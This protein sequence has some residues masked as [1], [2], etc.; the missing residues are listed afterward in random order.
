MSGSVF[1]RVAMSE[2]SLPVDGRVTPDAQQVVVELEGQAERPAEAP[3]RGDDARR[4]RWPGSAPAS[5]EPAMSA[6][7][8]RP[9]MSK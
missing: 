4:R 8:L 7:V 9:I 6:A 1:L 5:A 3:V 2:V